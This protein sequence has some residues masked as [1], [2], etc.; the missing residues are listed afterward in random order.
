MF[1]L[2]AIVVHLAQRFGRNWGSR[3]L[4]LYSLGENALLS[5]TTISFEAMHFPQRKE[6]M[7]R[8]KI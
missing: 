2:W 1:L 6:C 7:F 4:A 5:S 3:M 8:Q